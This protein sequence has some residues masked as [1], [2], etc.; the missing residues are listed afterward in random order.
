MGGLVALFG[1]LAPRGA[2]LKRSAADARLFETEARAV[3]FE[4][5]EDLSNRIDDPALDVTPAD[6]LVLKNAGPL[7]APG[8]PEAGYLPIRASSAGRV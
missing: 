6:A 1:S 4:S 3:V 5:L 7:G 2:I 8:M